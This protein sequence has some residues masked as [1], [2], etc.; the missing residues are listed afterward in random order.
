MPSDAAVADSFTVM[1]VGKINF[2]LGLGKERCLTICS[3]AWIVQLRF[4][5]LVATSVDVVRNSP[6]EILFQELS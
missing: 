6:A 3:P 1:P 2:C 4:E 5:E